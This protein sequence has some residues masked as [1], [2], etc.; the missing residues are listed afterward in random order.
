M[1]EY[2][3]SP[4]P[5]LTWRTI[6]GVLDFYVFLGPS[7]ENV[8]QQYTQMIGRPM[9]PPYWSL[10]FQ[11]CRYGYNNLTNMQ[12]AVEQTKSYDIPQDVQYADIDHMNESKIFTIDQVNFAGLADYFDMLRAGGMRT[13]II[14][15]P[16][17]I[18]NETDYEPYEEMKKVKA[19]I[20]WPSDFDIPANSSDEDGSMLGFVWPKGKVVFPDYFKSS[21][22]QVW[23]DLIVKHQ[24]QI[25]F[26][27]IWID[28]NEP[29]NF[30]TNEERPWNWP[31]DDKPYWS[32]HCG[33]NTLD[34]PPYRPL[35]AYIHDWPDSRK[36]LSDKTVCMNGVQG[37]R[38][39]Y[40]HYDVHSL[41]GWSQTAP[42]LEAARAATRER[43]LV[44]TRS[45]FP[46]S[47]KDAGH[48]LGDNYSGWEQ[49]RDSIIGML[50][51]NLF[52]IPY[53]G[54]DICGFFGN[55]T[56]DLCLRWMQLGAFYPYS[57]NHNGKGS[58]EQ[59]PGALGDNVGIASRE[60]METRYWL[61][62]YL[63][64]LF[65]QAHKQ[66]ETVVRPLHH[67]FSMDTKARGINDQFLWGPALLISPILYENQTE[68]TY[69]I[70]NGRWYHFYTGSFI[71]GPVEKTVPVSL[72]SKPELHLRG[73]H[74]IVLQEPA[75]NTHFSRMNTFQIR[76][77]LDGP[78]TANASAS[79]SLFWD[80]GQS[81]DTFESGNYFLANYRIHNRT[82]HVTVVNN[83]VSEVSSLLYEHVIVYGV[84]TAV[85]VIATRSDGSTFYPQ[86]SF[87]PYVQVLNVTLNDTFM[88]SDNFTIAWMNVEERVDCFPDA[89]SPAVNLTQE[90]CQQ[91]G[92]QFD[93]EAATSKTGSVVCFYS[94]DEGGLRYNVSRRED[95]QHGFKLHLTASGPYPFGGNFTSPVL[96]VQ[97]LSNQLLR[98]TFDDA[99]AVPPRYRVPTN[100]NI[101]TTGANN[102]LYTFNVTD[103]D[104]LSFVIIRKATGT[105]IFDTG[106]GGLVLSDQFLQLTTRLPSADLYGLGENTHSSFRRHFDKDN[107]W[108][109]FARDQFPGGDNNLYGVHPFYTCVE[110][111]H[112]NTHGVFLLNSNAQEYALSPGPMLTWRTIGGVLDF[113][114][115]LGPSPEN[116]VQQYTQVIGRPMMPPYWSLGFQLCRYGYNNLTNMQRAVEQTKSYDIPH[117]VQYADIDHMDE[118]KI[119]TI[120]QGNFAGLADYFDTLR[121][122]GM[123]TI[124][125]LDP[126]I[127][128]N[129]TNYEPYEEMK[130]VKANIMWPSDFD[131]PANSSDDDGSMLGFVWPKG[132]VVF[133]DYFKSVTHQVW[134]DL[135]VKH[136]QN[137]T[138]FDGIWIDMNEPA[139][140]GTNEERPWNWPKNDT[141]YWSLQCK[142]NSWDE[143]PYRPLAAYMY[144]NADNPRTLADKTVCMN[145]VQGDRGQYRHYDVHSLYGWSQTAPTLEAAR[146]AT[147]E[148][149]LVV[150]RSTF[151]GSGK[152][153]GHWLG[154]NTSV[155]S[156]LRQSI[157]GMLDFNLFGIPYIGADICGFFD[158]TT[159]ELCLRWMQLGAFYP[160]S[161]NHNGN[162]YNE[163]HP[164]A[165]GDNVGI[166][167]REI[168]E[169]RYWL[170]PYLYTLFHQAHT[171][172]ET[173][174]RPLHHEF[175][176]DFKARGIDRQFMWGPAL[177]IS[178]ILELNQT[179]LKYYLP[180]GRW[181]H[182]Y[183][184][185]VSM[186]PSEKTV[187][188]TLMSKP[189]LHLRGGHVLV[190]QAPANNTHF[191]RQNSFQIRAML[192]KAN[193][194]ARGSLFW[195]D[196]VSVDTYENGKY[197]LVNYTVKDKTLQVTVVANKGVSDVSSLDYEDVIVYGVTAANNVTATKTGGASFY[198]AFTFHTNL[199]MLNITLGNAVKLSEG[200]T[201]SWQ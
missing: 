145:G 193:G 63:Y 15:D 92:C 68:L 152:D 37:D 44:I 77:M 65:H 186:G 74:I 14:L 144:D 179:E 109:A 60:I 93:E 73:G 17:I 10:G 40:R 127:I 106:P 149:S 184:G 196:G 29:A 43:S 185:E 178:P 116:V 117:D 177:L 98:L 21:T 22:S 189:E 199:Q 108:A 11:L 76:V 150:T 85:N 64:T 24:N 174:V 129:E 31:E 95:T 125:I 187:P 82:L 165:L 141:P 148:R 171:Q 58:I 146:A 131:I 7:P 128:V 5:M 81:V 34:D 100:I 62:P 139:N 94:A 170:L 158:D 134:K 180:G 8:V 41:Y 88:L 113:Y 175:P 91:R 173:V 142:N 101:P 105:V 78:D 151:P 111:S 157:I 120:D 102:P 66:G 83:N 26:D 87:D 130:K 154:D 33:N 104:I 124:I 153:G 53:I 137:K 136:H 56:E 140:F 183:T 156:H 9:M 32:L 110:D 138:R 28:M 161:R 155:W 84:T 115:F 67:E 103:Q 114:V 119:F 57:R 132:K 20:M 135:I 121:A 4:G 97:M 23:K 46:G 164:G 89:R 38:G 50:D 133:P 1:T 18:V 42:T 75:N 47:G 61:L 195:D 197:T 163:Q 90:A 52:G 123:R 54:A 192:D 59:H 79:G 51:F 188:V 201:L 147:G 69:Y 159:E 194:S 55:T 3:L 2:E 16:C 198:P 30:G 80:D 35:A 118:R 122:G 72:M 99:G 25:R 191:S 181:Y 36:A 27:G 166:A 162:G 107:S 12:R 126:C 169:T 39:Q 182:F 168:M 190:L 200:F 49:L 112:G 167:S 176:M 71:V 172:G 160:Y 13:I 19:N 96:D 6:G 143:P 70:P 86:F 48:W 45:T